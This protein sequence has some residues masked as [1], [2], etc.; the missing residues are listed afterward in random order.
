M[1]VC[2]WKEQFQIS[3]K[4]CNL[5]EKYCYIDIIEDEIVSFLPN[6][7]WDLMVFFGNL[8]ATYILTKVGKTVQYIQDGIAQ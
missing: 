7:W 5:S 4:Y 2:S 8:L 3:K 1:F 6:A